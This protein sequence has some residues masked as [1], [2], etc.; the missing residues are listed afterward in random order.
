M[1]PM[2]PGSETKFHK[3]RYAMSNFL[4]EFIKQDKSPYD[5]SPYFAVPIDPLSTTMAQM[6]PNFK[7]FVDATNATEAA[8]GG[9]QGLLDIFTIREKYD[10]GQYMQINT[11]TMTHMDLLN[12]TDST[13]VDG[14]ERMKQ[15]LLKMVTTMKKYYQYV[16]AHAN[17]NAGAPINPKDFN[18]RI[19]YVQ[20][21]HNY[22][23]RN[24]YKVEDAA[25]GIKRKNTSKNTKKKNSKK[26]KTTPIK[27]PATAASS[28][29]SSSSSSSTG[30]SGASV[31]TTSFA[32]TTAATASVK[33]DTGLSRIT[34]KP[35]VDKIRRQQRM[36]L[37]LSLI[38]VNPYMSHVLL[39]SIVKRLHAH[40]VSPDTYPSSS[41][42]SSSASSS[43][44]S[45]LNKSLGNPNDYHNLPVARLEDDERLI[46][47]CS[48]Y[49]LGKNVHKKDDT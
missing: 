3:V 32:V 6:F 43:S 21:L 20:N 34:G 27:A 41:S 11:R 42:S 16:L 31:G 15:D 13:Y 49:L 29:S 25:Q 9:F 28:S 18:D 47:L 44:S 46:D 36:I 17:T 37:D 40:T 12:M 1:T 45:K 2:N 39:N 35:Q 38:F 5:K 4:K 23:E 8:T 14:A 22:I 10:R 26:K 30:G 24:F 7:E 19:L 48:L 33:E